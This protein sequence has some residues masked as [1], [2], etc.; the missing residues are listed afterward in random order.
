[1]KIKKMK[2]LTEDHLYLDYINQNAD[3][4]FP[5]HTSISLFLLSYCDCKTF[6]VFLVLPGDTVSGWTRLCEISIPQAVENFL[7]VS[8]DQVQSIPE[9][10]LRFEKKLGEPVRVHNDDKFEDRK[11]IRQKTFVK[12]ACKD[13]SSQEG[14][15]LSLALSKLTVQKTPVAVKREPSHIRKMKTSELPL[16]EHV[17]AE[18]LYFTLAD[19][20][21]FP[22]IHHF[23]GFSKKHQENLLRLPLIS[24]WFQR[25]QE[26]PG[27]KRAAANANM[28][29]LPHQGSVSLSDEHM[30]F[31]C[32]ASDEPQ[33]EHEDTSF[34]GGPRPTMTKL[35]K[36]GIE[37]TFSPHPC[38]SW[39]L[40]WTVSQM[41]CHSFKISQTHNASSFF[42]SSD[43]FLTGM[44]L[45]VI[46]L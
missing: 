25:V 27:I 33:E 12:E 14:R 6:R 30:Q 18:G 5:L 42:S 43:Q 29:F 3:C 38:P 20:V 11:F 22:C 15:L 36:S 9:E 7:S 44:L 10:V 24:S 46:F 8:S 37:A 45:L 26:V 23:F 40:D 31:I 34:I 2:G 28:Q 13:V 4:V 41:Y 39:A 17:F 19:V 32:T 35:M 1:L 21:L 16:L